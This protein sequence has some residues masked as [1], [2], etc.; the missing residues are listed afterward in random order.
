MDNVYLLTYFRKGSW[1]FCCNTKC[2][3]SLFENRLWISR[4]SCL[5]FK[6]SVLFYS[7][8]FGVSVEFKI[9]HF[10]KSFK[11]IKNNLKPFSA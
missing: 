10:E 2:S 7:Y 3:K 5:F 6:A 9:L 11:H 4:N 1:I 8:K